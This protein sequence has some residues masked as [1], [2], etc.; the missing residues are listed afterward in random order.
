MV[1]AICCDKRTTVKL[2]DTP[3]DGGVFRAFYLVP[4]VQEEGGI[5]PPWRGYFSFPCTEVLT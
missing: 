2:S 4:K 1:I 3:P 5:T